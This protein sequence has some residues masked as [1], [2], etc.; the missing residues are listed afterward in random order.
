VTAVLALDVGGTKLAA[1][2]VD[3]DATVRRPRRVPTGD[4]PWET[5][6]ELLEE[7]RAGEPLLGVG[8]GCG[9]PITWPSGVVAPHNTPPWRAGFP[10]LAALRGAYDGL[11]VQMHNDAVTVAVGEHWAGA[12]RGT[13]DLLGMVVSTGVGGGIVRSG[14]VV[15]GR[16]GNAG[17]VGH[18]VVEPGGA[19]CGCG[20]RGCVEALARGPA[21]VAWARERGCAAADGRELAVAAAAADPVA[22][23]AFARAGTALGLGIA[24]AAALLDVDLVVLGGGLSQA[25]EPLWGPLRQAL[26]AHARLGYLA[27]LRVVPTQL[28]QDSGLVGAAALVHA[29]DRYATPG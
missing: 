17:H 5:L 29:R 20:G 3:P 15:A 8:V 28:G 22:L 27:G 9:G 25:G 1:A 26:H 2:L 23:A 12:G 16:S 14:R 4:Q 11:P 13:E 6:L 10:L 19:R 7:V 18:L 21:V 24:G